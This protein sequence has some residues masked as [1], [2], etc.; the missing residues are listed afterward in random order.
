MTRPYV[1]NGVVVALTVL[2]L[3]RVLPSWVITFGL[4]FQTWVVLTLGLL[5]LAP[6]CAFTYGA[7]KGR[8]A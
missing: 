2:V 4:S 7:W 1:V 8:Q 3:A 5:V 6:V